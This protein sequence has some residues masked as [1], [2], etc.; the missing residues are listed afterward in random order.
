ML[1]RDGAWSEEN[2]FSVT[3]SEQILACSERRDKRPVSPKGRKSL[4]AAL[5]W[6]NVVDSQLCEQLLSPPCTSSVLF[7]K[8]ERTRE[9]ML[10]IPSINRLYETYSC[11]VIHNKY[12]KAV[13]PRFAS[14]PIYAHKAKSRFDFDLSRAFKLMCCCLLDHNVFAPPRPVLLWYQGACSHSTVQGKRNTSAPAVIAEHTT[15]LRLEGL[16][17]PWAEFLYL[18]YSKR[19]QRLLLHLAIHQHKDSKQVFV[20]GCV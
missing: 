7:V 15:G 4:R 3:I 18:P 8:D 9:K 10:I 1:Q 16:W 5:E 20:P 2:S 6:K 14:L 11:P 19:A 12:L 17:L 13:G